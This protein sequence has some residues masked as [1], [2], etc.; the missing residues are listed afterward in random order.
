MNKPTSRV[1]VWKSRWKA[2]LWQVGWS[3]LILGLTLNILILLVQVSLGAALETPKVASDLV[4]TL[5]WSL[6]VCLGL[7]IGRSVVKPRTAIMIVLGLIA[8]PIATLISRSLSHGF[9]K[10]IDAVGSLDSSSL[11]LPFLLFRAIEYSV[12]SGCLGWAIR[13]S[14]WV[15]LAIG[16][17]IGAI[18]GGFWLYFLIHIQ[19]SPL[20]TLTLISLALNELLFPI[21]CAA[22]LKLAS[23]RQDNDQDSRKSMP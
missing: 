23:D 7:A 22:V 20:S 3:S 17:A 4:K 12:L 6:L 21:G 11:L 15:H 18:F 19:P 8:A 9:K 13:K 5:T 2:L 10:A 1:A 16:A 14:L